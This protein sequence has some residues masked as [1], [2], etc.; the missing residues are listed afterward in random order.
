MHCRS[1][2]SSYLNLEHRKR[3]KWPWRGW[4]LPMDSN[5]LKG[6][7][8]KQRKDGWQ[9]KETGAGQWKIMNQK[10]TA[11]TA[12]R[13]SVHAV[14]VVGLGWGEETCQRVGWWDS[15][16]RKL[17]QIQRNLNR[18]IDVIVTKQAN[19]AQCQGRCRKRGG[20]EREEHNHD[21]KISILIEAWGSRGRGRW[22]DSYL[23][24]LSWT[25]FG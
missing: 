23:R 6:Q 8:T 13:M 17:D 4:N 16:L 2:I 12:C 24:K 15:K 1:A 14:V 20:R 10:H 21:Q 3:S 19:M 25:R 22:R 11:P 18:W 5:S 7:W 9:V